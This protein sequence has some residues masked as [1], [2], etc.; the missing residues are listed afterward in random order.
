MWLSGK[1]AFTG[2]TCRILPWASSAS[3]LTLPSA[4][5]PGKSPQREPRAPGL[6]SGSHTARPVEGPHSP[7]K[8]PPLPALWVRGL[9]WILGASSSKSGLSQGNLLSSLLAGGQGQVPVDAGW[10]ALGGVACQEQ[11]AVH[12][13][14]EGFSESN[15]E[16]AAGQGSWSC[17]RNQAPKARR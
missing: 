6:A 2:Q 12:G 10:V 17:S 13:L 15:A 8:P 11:Y 1:I 4:R 7:G 16:G 5:S 3:R 14:A 9:K